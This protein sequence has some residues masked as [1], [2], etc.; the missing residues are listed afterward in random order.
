MPENADLENVRAQSEH[1]VLQIVVPKT[2]KSEPKRITVQNN[3]PQISHN[4]CVHERTARPLV[5]YLF[6]LCEISY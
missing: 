2:P 6:E 5:F 4:Y 3:A 1:G